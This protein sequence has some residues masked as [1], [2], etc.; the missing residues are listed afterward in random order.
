MKLPHTKLGFEKG[1]IM[2]AT[3]KSINKEGYNCNQG[4]ETM[5]VD[6]IMSNHWIWCNEVQKAILKIQKPRRTNIIVKLRQFYGS[7]PKYCKKKD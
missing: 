6:R 3:M 2:I 7:N 5:G 4:R 1:W